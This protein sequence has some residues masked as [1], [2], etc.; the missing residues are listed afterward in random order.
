VSQ[1]GDG[2]TPSLEV[3]RPSMW[4]T[5]LAGA[6]WANQNDTSSSWDPRTAIASQAA[7]RDQARD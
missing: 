4:E 2:E 3:I 5:A 7:A 1:A 6:G